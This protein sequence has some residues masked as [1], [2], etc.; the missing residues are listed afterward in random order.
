MYWD[1]QLSLVGTPEEL[2]G[3]EQVV[4]MRIPVTPSVVDRSTQEVAGIV[5]FLLTSPDESVIQPEWQDDI[6]AEIGELEQ[7]VGIYNTLC[8]NLLPLVVIL[9]TLPKILR[10]A[11]TVAVMNRL[12][13]SVCGI[14]TKLVA[15]AQVPVGSN[16]N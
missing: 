5:G 3:R 1:I 4:T 16:M 14:R 15:P 11:G 10:P 8:I 12:L 13:R 9:T 7:P 2:D 6:R